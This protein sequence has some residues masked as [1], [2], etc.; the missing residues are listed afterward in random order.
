MAPATIFLAI[1]ALFGAVFLAFSAAI[2]RIFSRFVHLE[3][4]REIRVDD[5]ARGVV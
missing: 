5:F 2:A 4:V 3:K 1:C